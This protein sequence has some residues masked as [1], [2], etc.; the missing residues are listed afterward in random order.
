MSQS[1]IIWL[2]AGILC[3]ISAVLLNYFNNIKDA[4]NGHINHSKAL[5]IKAGSCIPA[6]ICLALATNFRWVFALCAA[7]FITGSYFFL[8]FELLWSVKVYNS[9]FHKGTSIGKNK[10]R[11]DKLLEDWPI[12]AIIAL[13]LVLCIVSAWFYNFGL[14]K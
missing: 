5:K 9:P 3:F 11:T 6:I 4:K 8:L 12:P 7:S 13:K 14:K 10:G 2:I 1:S